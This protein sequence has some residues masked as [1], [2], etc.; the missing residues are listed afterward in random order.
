MSTASLWPLCRCGTSPANQ[1]LR[2]VRNDWPHELLWCEDH[3]GSHQFALAGTWTSQQHPP[4]HAGASELPKLPADTGQADGQ[5]VGQAD[6]DLN[7]GCSKSMWLDGNWVSD[8]LISKTLPLFIF[9]YLPLFIF[10]YLP[11]FIFVYL[12]LFIFVY[13][14]LFIFV[15]LPLF[16]FVYLPL[17][18]F[19]YLC[20]SSFVYLCLSSF[21]YLCL[22]SFVY[23]CL[24]SFVYLCLS[25]FIFLCLSLFIFVCFQDSN[26]WVSSR[27]SCCCVNSPLFHL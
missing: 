3:P 22:S 10:V 12:P 2:F 9:V 11:L 15:Y 26:G 23:L 7:C 14:P 6:E 13:L 4:Q 18:I 27:G 8:F 24:S 25:L 21:V 20:L 5:A 17:F 1:P 16:I 19:V